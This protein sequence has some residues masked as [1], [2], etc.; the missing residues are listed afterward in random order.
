MSETK[1]LELYEDK[2]P[3]VAPGASAAETTASPE[4]P[5]SSKPKV[6]FGGKDQAKAQPR[7]EP[8]LRNEGR[9]PSGS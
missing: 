7:A 9:W 5:A 4:V 6:E 1:E 2:V 3:D 8:Q